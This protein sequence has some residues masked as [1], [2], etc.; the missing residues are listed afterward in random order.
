LRLYPA[1]FRA[2]YE[3]EMVRLFT[4]Q[5]ADARRT[6]RRWDLVDLWVRTLADVSSNAAVEQLAVRRAPARS[7]I[8]PAGRTLDFVDR[9]GRAHR[10][11]LTVAAAPIAM[12][13][14][15]AVVAPGYTDPIYANP[16]S[17]LGLPAGLLLVCGAALWAAAAFVLLLKARSTPVH[18]LAIVLFT[19]PATMLVILA[20]PVILII[21]NLA[22]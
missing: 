22:V 1:G 14:L 11:F 8:D 18:V 4:D 10:V 21:E 17:I 12:I 2:S 9:P 13:V 7:P 3:D 20:P 15:L 6:G 19:L 16:P 5:L